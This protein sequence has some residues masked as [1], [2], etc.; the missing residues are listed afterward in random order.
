ME[1]VSRRI[2]ELEKETKLG[3]QLESE[4]EMRRAARAQMKNIDNDTDENINNMNTNPDD[5]G[6]IAAA[7]DLLENTDNLKAVHSTNSVAAMVRDSRLPAAEECNETIFLRISPTF[8][9]FSS[10]SEEE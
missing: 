6:A 3:A 9:S 7:K 2:Q 5:D 8:R 4:A 1:M 10:A